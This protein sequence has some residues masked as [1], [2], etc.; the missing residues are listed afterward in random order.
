MPSPG[1]AVTS[2]A[3][4][5]PDGRS[6]GAAIR[7]Y[8]PGPPVTSVGYQLLT[9]TNLEAARGEGKRL[10]QAGLR[11][12]FRAGGRAAP[13][14]PCCPLLAARGEGKQLAQAG[15]RLSFVRGGAPPR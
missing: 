1:L 14:A 2:R 13:V 15:L 5:C 3:T 10:A 6:F 12:S 9:A 7:T 8:S 4:G 11:L